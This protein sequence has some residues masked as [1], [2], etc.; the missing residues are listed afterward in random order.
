MIGVKFY[1]YHGIT[2]FF[3]ISSFF[4]LLYNYFGM[5]ARN[6]TKTSV[7]PQ[8]ILPKAYNLLLKNDEYQNVFQ[9][10]INPE[11]ILNEHL[12]NTLL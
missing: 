8:Y 7:I 6:L 12:I 2:C 1:P 4:R 9:N 10:L 5:T 3:L 11:D